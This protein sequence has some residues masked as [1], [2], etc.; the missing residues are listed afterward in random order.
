MAVYVDTGIF[1]ALN[2]KSDKNHARSNVLMEKALK[3]EY[4]TVYTSDYVIDEAVTT[5]L[6]RTRDYSIAFRT[7]SFIIE[8]MRIEKIYTSSNEFEMGWQTFQKL[9]RKP[10][11]FTDCI[12]L[13]HM[14]KRGLEKIMSFDSEFDGLVTR[15]Y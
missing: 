12:S 14:N 7:G 9:R 8:S 5:A 3:G 1:V 2:N 15:M 10:M 13:A 4:G 6:A 11:S